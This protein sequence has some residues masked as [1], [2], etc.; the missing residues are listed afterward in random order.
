M[1]SKIKKKMM[2]IKVIIKIKNKHTL[3]SIPNMLLPGWVIIASESTEI[4]YIYFFK[5]IFFEEI[6]SLQQN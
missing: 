2:K 4:G 6:L 3:Y 1:L 5:T